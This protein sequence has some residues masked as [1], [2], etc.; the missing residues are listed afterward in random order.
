MA[1]IANSPKRAAGNHFE[2]QGFAEGWLTL[3]PQTSS[4]ER[5][6]QVPWKAGIDATCGAHVIGH[7]PGRHRRQNR[8]QKEVRLGYNQVIAEVGA[9]R[10]M[11]G[12]DGDGMRHRMIPLDTGSLAREA[13]SPKSLSNVIRTRS[14]A[15]ARV[16]TCRSLLPGASWQI[17]AT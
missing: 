15:S 6:A 4:S 16:R 13:S 3:C 1:E 17:H 7:G 14:P 8:G 12:D 11:L 2:A 10:R 9:E 5:L